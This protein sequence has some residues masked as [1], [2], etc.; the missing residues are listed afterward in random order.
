MNSNYENLLSLV[1][2]SKEH[3]EKFFVKENKSAGTRLRKSLGEIKKASQEL[4]K[5]IQAMK[6]ATKA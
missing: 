5:E 6:T 4:R 1:E 3:A 2:A